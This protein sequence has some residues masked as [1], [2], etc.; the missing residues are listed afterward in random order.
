MLI[1]TATKVLLGTSTRNLQKQ[2]RDY[3]YSNK[4]KIGTLTRVLKSTV[5]NN[6]TE[7]LRCQKKKSDQDAYGNKSTR[8]PF[9]T[10]TTIKCLQE[11]TQLPYGFLM[12][13]PRDT[14][15]ILE[16]SRKLGQ[17]REKLSSL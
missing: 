6:C 1:I 8:L 16:S 10:G 9:R 4:R 14:Q 5:Q 12:T 17:L 7:T 15:V 13:V 3:W 11:P 2:Q